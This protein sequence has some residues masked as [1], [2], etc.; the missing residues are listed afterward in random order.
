MLDFA[1][2]LNNTKFLTC[3]EKSS[4][5]RKLTEIALDAKSYSKDRKSFERLFLYLLADWK[6]MMAYDHF[7]RPSIFTKLLKQVLDKCS[8]SLKP[9][10]DSEAAQ[11]LDSDAAAQQ[12]SKP[13]PREIKQVKIPSD[14]DLDA[15]EYFE[16][17]TLVGEC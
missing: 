6:L 4:L 11:K 10:L 9:E 17:L 12:A 14:A 8:A 7:G 13:D 5:W 1:I 16:D 2:K 15:R 3:L